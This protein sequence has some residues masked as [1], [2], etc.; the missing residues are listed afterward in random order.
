[1][2]K[3]PSRLLQV[4][5]RQS[6][7]NAKMATAATIRKHIAVQ[8]SAVN[9]LQC[10]STRSND[11]IR[12]GHSAVRGGK[13]GTSA[14]LPILHMVPWQR[15]GRLAKV[16]RDVRGLV[17]RAAMHPKW[18]KRTARRA[19]L[20][21]IEDASVADFDMQ[22]LNMVESQVR[23]SDVTDRR[24]MRAMLDLPREAFVP[25]WARAIAY[26]DEDVAVSRNRG[27]RPARTMLAPRTLAKLIQAAEVQGG[28]RV[29][30]IGCATGY[31]T[32]VLAHLAGEVIGLE[33]DVDLAVAARAALQAARLTNA[34]IEQGALPQGWVA[35]A[36]YDVIL[37]NGGVSE[38]P[39]NLLAQL[40]DG[41]RL[42]AVITRSG[43]F[44][45]AR[46]Q[47][48]R[49]GA[50]SQKTAFDAGASPLPGFE[51]VAAF[52]L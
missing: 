17:A 51:A 23:P 29:L 32:A 15:H 43:N 5:L 46:V 40:K 36:P 19:D 13:A 39:G 37:M 1:M 4:C 7:S 48:K 10:P 3:D 33:E 22:R 24:L 28:D 50:S 31:S 2:R 18:V 49:G 34:R 12:R 25:V 8:R 35:A 27:G 45:T 38:V 21:P 41:G 20:M 14:E 6:K 42:V 26:S 47:T 11:D 9:H 30:D 44:G 16:R 52:S